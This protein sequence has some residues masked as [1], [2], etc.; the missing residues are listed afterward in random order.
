[1]PTTSDDALLWRDAARI[2]NAAGDSTTALARYRRALAIIEPTDPAMLNDDAAFSRA[3]RSRE[4]D[5]WLAAS[6]RAD[7][8]ALY[9]SRHTHIRADRLVQ[10]DSGTHGVSELTTATD[11]LEIDTPFGAGRGFLRLDR[12]ALDAGRLERDGGGLNRDEFGTCTATGCRNDF[13]QQDSGVSVG[14]GWYDNTWRVDVGTTPIGF[15][16]TDWVGGLEY[17]GELG[18]LWATAELSR[19][20]LTG[21]LLSYAGTQDPNTGKTWGGVRATGVDLGLGVDQG[22]PNGVWSNLGVHHLSGENVPDNQR[23]RLMGGIYH[24]LINRPDER[25]SIGVNTLAMHYRENLGGY[26]FGQGGYYS[27]RRYLSF[28]LPVGYRRRTS[29][30]SWSLEAALSHS[31]TESGPRERYPLGDAFSASLPDATARDASSRGGGIGF[32]AAATLERRLSAHWRAGLALDAQQSE[33]YSP[34]ALQ[35]YLRFSPAPWQGDLDLPPAPL[36]PYA[37]GG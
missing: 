23:L 5:D 19:R 1:M 4:D 28:S 20:P 27:P 13:D 37:D 9:R 8:A 21:S 15:A 34:N 2:A 22:G 32:S 25:L 10:N 29:D 16:V 17:N 36:T 30:W 35:F 31:W 11:M 3:L 33:G 14:V 24:K 26:S 12:V 6:L 7:A 18:P